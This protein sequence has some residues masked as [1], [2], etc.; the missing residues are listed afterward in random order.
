[1]LM[2]RSHMGCYVL[3]ISQELSVSVRR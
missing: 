1:M 2:K 3:P